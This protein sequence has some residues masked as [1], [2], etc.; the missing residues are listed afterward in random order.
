[1]KALVLAALSVL[2]LA[3]PPAFAQSG[4]TK[5]TAMSG[6]KSQQTAGQPVHKASGKVTQVDPANGAVTIAHD[7]VPALKWSAMTMTFKVKDKT[8]LDK[9]KPGAKVDFSFIDSGKQYV[10]VDIRQ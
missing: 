5:G 8:A 7:P 3:V 6:N 4:E 10:I 9:V 1:M 2:A